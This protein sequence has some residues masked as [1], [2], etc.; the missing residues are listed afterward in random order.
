MRAK[1]ALSPDA[2]RAIRSF[3]SIPRQHSASLWRRARAVEDIGQ[4]A[5]EAD[6]EGEDADKGQPA[7]AAPMKVI[8]AAKETVE[9]AGRHGPEENEQRNADAHHVDAAGK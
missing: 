9:V 1:A 6:H 5:A 8:A 4:H 2:A 3:V 7:G